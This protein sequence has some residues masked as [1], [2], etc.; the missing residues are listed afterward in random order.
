MFIPFYRPIEA[1]M[2]LSSIGLG[3]RRL[4][5]KGHGRSALRH[6]NVKRPCAS[7]RKD[8]SSEAPTLLSKAKNTFGFPREVLASIRKRGQKQVLLDQPCDAFDN[9][10]GLFGLWPGTLFPPFS[11][12]F[13]YNSRGGAIKASFLSSFYVFTRRAA[14]HNFLW[15]L[16]R[17]PALGRQG[18]LSSSFCSRR[19]PF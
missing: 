13:P 15:P 12:P 17:F 14:K 3:L 18:F 11:R 9:K 7:A 16:A 1:Q 5:D 10:V 2:V 8:I 6:R 4:S 19:V